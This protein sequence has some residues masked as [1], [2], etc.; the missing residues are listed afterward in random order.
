MPRLLIELTQD[1]WDELVGEAKRE[2]RTP[3]MQAA[4]LLSRVLAIPWGHSAEAQG[5]ARGPGDTLPAQEQVG[6]VEGHGDGAAGGV[7]QVVVG[8]PGEPE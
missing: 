2:R 8:G 4:V 5:A 6:A 1:E 7:H 3:Q